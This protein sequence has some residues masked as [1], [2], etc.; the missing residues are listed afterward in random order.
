MSPKRTLR[1]SR[2]A[3][4]VSRV[5]GFPVL[6]RHCPQSTLRPQPGGEGKPGQLTVAPEVPG[7]SG[8]GSDGT[9]LERNTTAGRLW[10]T[11]R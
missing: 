11:C 4:I 10:E 7:A 8:P 1:G 5:D 9:G 6:L 3:L 2:W